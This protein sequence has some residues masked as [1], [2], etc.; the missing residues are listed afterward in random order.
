M[1]A[2]DPGLQNIKIVGDRNHVVQ[3]DKLV[4]G[5]TYIQQGEQNQA[6]FEVQL[7]TLRQAAAPANLA[8]LAEHARQH[9][10]ALL[11]GSYDDKLTLARQVARH[12]AEEQ[13]WLEEAETSARPVLEWAGNTS[14]AALLR[15]IEQQDRPSVLVLP[16]VLPQHLGYDVARLRATAALGS[17]VVVATTERAREAWQVATGAATCWYGLEPEGLFS[18]DAL[19]LALCTGLEDVRGNL[20]AGAL[21]LDAQP[22]PTLAG[23]PLAEIAGDLQTPGNVEFFVQQL[24]AAGPNEPLDAERIDALVQ[25]TASG[26]NRV[27]KWFH[28]VLQPDEQVLALSLAFFD[29]LYD[30]QYFAALERWVEHLRER[31]NPAQRAFDYCDLEAMHAFVTQVE[32]S[33][34]GIR[35]T[36]RWSRQRYLLLQSAWRTH[37]RTMLSALP[38][39]TELAASSVPGRGDDWELYGSSERREQIREAIGG[40]LS[41]IGLISRAGVQSALLQLAADPEFAV[42]AVAAR[43]VAR[44]RES[45]AHEQLFETL[46]GWQ[47][48]A[49]MHGVIEAIL[50]GRKSEKA[51]GPMAYIRATIAVAV[52]YAS[53]YDPPGQ[54]HAGLLELVRTLSED[55][56]PM[57]RDRF[58]RFTLP[59]VASLHLR[60]LRSSLRRMMADEW[61]TDDI[62]A[63]LAY[64]YGTIPDEVLETLNEWQREAEKKSDTID[65]RK[66]TDRDKLL[67]AVAFTYGELDYTLDGPISA[68]HGFRWLQHILATERHPKVRTAAV[69]AI[70]M[71]AK[72]RF[73]K[74]EPLMQTLVAEVMK[75]E[76]DEVVRIL[77]D[78]YQEQRAA[79]K[80]GTVQRTVNGELLWLWTDGSRPSTEV[81]TAML[82]WLCD[83]QTPA[84][85][86]IAM[87]AFM[88]FAMTVDQPAG[89]EVQRYREERRQRETEDA[90]ALVASTPVRVAQEL[91]WY[92]GSYVPWLT[93]LG[94]GRYARIIRALLPEALAQGA[95]NG[96]T[97][98]FVLRRWEREAGEAAPVSRYLRSA[99]RWHGTAWML[100]PAAALALLALLVVLF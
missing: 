5:P 37:R 77:A 29:D 58:G 12:L 55:R 49:R 45:G 75:E 72:R 28:G 90:A 22:L 92:T 43:A 96:S 81:E 70:S 68:D 62:G 17:H 85:Q 57:V 42:Q 1:N 34:A 36:S 74:V 53:G 39:L 33:L 76:R 51:N 100:I 35:Y 44:W 31:R 82:R 97:L 41:D 24:A 78:I 61:L 15:G 46:K 65:P 79:L 64:A 16:N 2:T 87:Q 27:E 73:A 80:G 71:Q 4:S 13:R 83:P 11:G 63:A 3:V 47:N 52:A 26:M 86:Q 84:A 67:L 21:D 20:P 30:D 89:T 9:G 59:W 6:F 40:A 98:E 88:A 18:S 95:A 69:V 91:G 32:S 10:V 50:E 66:L 19:N 56:N 38:I 48:D 8:E 23:V 54:L 25:V 7:A 60:Q 14:H 99:V 93:T 94:A